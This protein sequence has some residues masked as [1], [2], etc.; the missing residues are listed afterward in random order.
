MN[1][2]DPSVSLDRHQRRRDAGLPTVSVLAGPV[3]L[4]TREAR[5]WAEGRGRAV[6]A[7]DGLGGDRMADAWADAMAEGRDLAEDALSHLGRSGDGAASRVARMTPLELGLFL[8]EAGSGGD[9]VSATCR[10][11]L[12]RR[13]A[14]EPRGRA[15]IA[16]RLASVLGSRERAVVA[17]AGL[18]PPGAGPVLVAEGCGGADALARLALLQPRLTPI[19]AVDPAVLDDYLGATPESREKALIRSGIVAVVDVGGPPPPDAGAPDDRARSEAERYLAGCLADHPETAGLFELNATLDIPFGPGRSMEV[20]L[21]CLA[22]RVAVEVDGY[23]HFR[24]DEGYRRDRRK[25]L[26]LQSR[27]YLVVRVLADDVVRR[28]EDVLAL[29][30]SA[31]ASRRADAPSPSNRDA[32]P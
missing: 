4:A 9:D 6:V 24:D 14:G 8:D 21:A 25:D 15:G 30:L 29:I 22:L 18:V 11:L 17:V 1:D 16:A 12:G 3:G 27:G 13:A 7:A 19:L 10:W 5:R 23:H 28:L 2:A 20:D 31:V 32:R 26:L